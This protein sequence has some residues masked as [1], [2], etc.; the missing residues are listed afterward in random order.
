MSMASSPQRWTLSARIVV[1][2]PVIHR[3]FF[4]L[5]EELTPSRTTTGR[6]LVAYS[7]WVDPSMIIGVL[8][9]GS[10][11]DGRMTNDCGDAV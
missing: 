4:S 3:P 5:P 7:G 8:I 11:V 1:P 6:A 9:A 10:S 2:P